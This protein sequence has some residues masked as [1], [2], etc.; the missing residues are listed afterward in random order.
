MTHTQFM[1][2]VFESWRKTG[3]DSPRRPQWQPK[4]KIGSLSITPEV[5]TH[6][7]LKNTQ[8]NESSAVHTNGASIMKAGLGYKLFAI[9]HFPG[10]KAKDQKHIL[11]N[12]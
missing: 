10:L 12:V 3:H 2:H 7:R 8:Q 6:S 9:V 1:F 5:D 4:K 11:M